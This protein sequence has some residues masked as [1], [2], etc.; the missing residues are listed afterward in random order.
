MR[1]LLFPLSIIAIVSLMTSCLSNWESNDTPRIATSMF[2]V[3]PVMQGDSVV[4]AK[5]TMLIRY[6][7]EDDSYITD[8]L[9]LG[10]TILFASSFYSVSNN[11]V[12][13][14]MKWDSTE[15]ALWYSLSEA[16][17]K[18]L[19]EQS[20]MAAG[21][22]YFNPGYNLVSFPIYVSPVVEGKTSIELVIESDSKYSTNSLR[23]AVPVSKVD[24]VS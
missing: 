9:A 14:K 18:V 24:S 22:L 7:M 5:D 8:T 12:A 13:I 19:T 16:T 11:L 4:E 15:T 21:V 6:D 23:F 2:L 1:K 17:Q 10:D 3:N 20:D